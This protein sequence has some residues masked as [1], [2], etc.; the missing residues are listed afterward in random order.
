MSENSN[1]N[2]EDI[3]QFPNVTAF[4]CLLSQRPKLQNALCTA[5][6]DTENWKA[7]TN[8]FL[9]TFFI[10]TLLTYFKTPS[11]HFFKFTFTSPKTSD[12][13]KT[14]LC[15]YKVCHS[16][17]FHISLLKETRL[18]TFSKIWHSNRASHICCTTNMKTHEPVPS[19]YF[20]FH[21]A[22]LLASLAQRSKYISQSKVILSTLQHIWKGTLDGR[23]TFFWWANGLKQGF[24]NRNPEWGSM[25]ATLS[26]E[27]MS[28]DQVNYTILE[29]YYR[30]FGQRGWK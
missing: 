28:S 12:L 29:C 13:D 3:F 5:M 18:C 1:K 8:K 2:V 25:E 10:G 24:V 14:D 22:L 16:K 6:E 4:F 7:W 23:L 9:W 19:R 30:I 17:C 11:M 20:A 27:E 15:L 26:L 21:R